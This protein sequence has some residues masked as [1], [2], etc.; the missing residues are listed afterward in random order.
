[1]IQIRFEINGRRVDPHDLRGAFEQAIFENIRE[2]LR[3]KLS[4]VPDLDTGESP[5]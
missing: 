1:M 5:S 3:S 2:R 4:N